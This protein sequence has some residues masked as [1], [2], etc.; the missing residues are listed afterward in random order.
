M[1]RELFFKKFYRIADKFHWISIGMTN[2]QSLWKVRMFMVFF[3]HN[4]NKLPFFVFIQSRFNQSKFS[5]KASK[6]SKSAETSISL[7][8]RRMRKGFSLLS[9]SRDSSSE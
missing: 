8:P 3:S 7:T 2:Y 5:T 1:P 6:E 9:T 4:P